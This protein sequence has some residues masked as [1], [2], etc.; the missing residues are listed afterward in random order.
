MDFSTSRIETNDIKDHILS[1]IELI[2]K[3]VRNFK[4]EADL[5]RL[6]RI[7]EGGDSPIAE[8]LVCW[9][10]MDECICVGESIAEYGICLNCGEQQ[11]LQL[12]N[13]VRPFLKMSGM[14]R[15]NYVP[16]TKNVMKKN[17]LFMLETGTPE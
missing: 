9:N 16:T 14:M 7:K 15:S 5:L 10:C 3:S 12:V 4:E 8:G 13:I 11:M 6:A 2:D 17:R 1:A